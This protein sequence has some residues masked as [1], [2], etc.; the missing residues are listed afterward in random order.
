MVVRVFGVFEE[1]QTA[2]CGIAVNP[3]IEVTTGLCL[4][5]FGVIPYA[6]ILAAVLVYAWRQYERSKD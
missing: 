6:A 2:V 3:D 5:R 4:E 1:S